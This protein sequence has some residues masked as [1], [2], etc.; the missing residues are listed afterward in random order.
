MSFRDGAVS[1]RATVYICVCARYV[2]WG[3]IMRKFMAD[4]ANKASKRTVLTLFYFAHCRAKWRRAR[5]SGRNRRRER[6]IGPATR[7]GQIPQRK[8]NVEPVR[9]GHSIGPTP[10]GFDS[11]RRISTVGSGGGRSRLPKCSQR[12]RNQEKSPRRFAVGPFGT[13]KGDRRWTLQLLH[14]GVG[15]KIAS[16]TNEGFVSA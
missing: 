8:R 6:H 1:L 12:E 3:P 11:K 7:I 13:G 14:R 16:A 10:G 4:T 15:R 5:R 2:L 9:G